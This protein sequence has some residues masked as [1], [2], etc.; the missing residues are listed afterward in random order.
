MKRF[1][2]LGLAAAAILMTGCGSGGGGGVANTLVTLHSGQ[3]WVFQYTG[4][5]K[6]TGGIT[7]NV[8]ADSTVTFTVS[9]TT[10]KDLNNDTVSILERK[11]NLKLLDGTPVKANFRQYFTQTALGIFVHGYNNYVGDTVNSADDKFV[12]GTVTPAY[13]FLFMPSP[14]SG[15]VTYPNPFGVSG[16]G[17][18]SYAFAITNAKRVGVTVPAG[19]FSAMTGSITEKYD[20]FTLTSVG[21][22][23]EVA[24]GMISGTL[25]ATFPDGS[26]LSG[27]ILLKSAG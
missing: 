7:Q 4:T 8:T 23:P 9:N 16:A 26:E 21:L 13:A 15:N 20:D 25:K 27:T 19:T 12:P 1:L 17:D 5:V 3:T 18:H 22:V 10:S 2:A 14:V 6:L 24:G 11:F